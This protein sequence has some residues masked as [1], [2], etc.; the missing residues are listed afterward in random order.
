VPNDGPAFTDAEFAVSCS[1]N[2][3]CQLIPLNTYKC[4]LAVHGKNCCS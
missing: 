3:S 2:L 4:L 1:V